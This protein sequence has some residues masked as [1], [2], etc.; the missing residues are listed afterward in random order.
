M[1]S[2]DKRQMLISAAIDLFAQQGFWNSTTAAIAKHAKVATG[3][4][5]N[6]F[7]S[8]Q[9]LID[10]VYIEIKQMLYKELSVDLT[11]EFKTS[12]RK[13]WGIYIH[14]SLKSPVHHDLLIQLKQSEVVSQQVEQQLINQFELFTQLVNQQLQ[15]SGLFRTMDLGF[16]MELINHQLEA[17]II[18]AKRQQFSAKEL[19]QHIDLGF[20]VLWQGFLK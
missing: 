11:G 9:D 1:A 19:K 12:L 2:K 8:K 3:T 4:L 13:L 20:S 15:P 5:F 10:G 18:H 17:N 6:Y 7:P 14:W 16:A